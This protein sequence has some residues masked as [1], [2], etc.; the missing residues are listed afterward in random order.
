MEAET[1][2][3]EGG[4]LHTLIAHADAHDPTLSRIL[5]TDTNININPREKAQALARLGVRLC[6][7]EKHTEALAALR[8]ATE[9][10]PTDHRILNNLAVVLERAHQLPDAI[11]AARRSLALHP[12]QPDVWLHLANMLKSHNEP[13]AAEHAYRTALDLEPTSPIGW[14]MLGLLHQEN[15]RF[16]DAIDCFLHCAK[17]GNASAPI[18]A[19]LGQLFHQTG[20][21]EKSLHAYSAAAD[22]DPTN[23]TYT[24][25]RRRVAFLVDLLPPP[26]VDEAPARYT[27]ARPPAAPQNARNL[28]PLLHNAFSLLSGYGH[29]DAAQRVGQKRLALHPQSPS[30]AYLLK[31]LSGDQSLPRSPD[32]YLVE[33]F[34]AFADGFDQQLTG[35][36]GYDVPRQLADLDLPPLH[37]RKI[38]I[39]DLGCGTGL[40]GLHIAPHAQTLTG[41]DLSPKMLERARQRNLYQHL[42]CQEITTFLHTSSARADLLLAAD[43]LIYFGELSALFQGFSRAL[44]PG[45]I[46]ALSI[47]LTENQPHRLLP[48]GR[49][50]H[51]PDHLRT[52]A[53]HHGLLELT[54]RNTTLRL[55]AATPVPGQLLAF[56]LPD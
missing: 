7:Q 31:A 51:D 32:A 40:C 13:V 52:L 4:R 42:F 1:P 39:L 8:A 36:L 55:E 50:A 10:A 17:N 21:F 5:T 16:K 48:S 14:Q 54:S 24:D 18:F 2:L 37:K 43:V 33:Y 26:T 29:H 35:L 20:N 27:A 53:A 11:D 41:V 56:Y 19:I 34:D 49:F 9:L 44:N 25:T 23:P 22:L 15:R 3:L 47:E 12:N 6:L 46:L 45:G 30:A 38:D 28:D